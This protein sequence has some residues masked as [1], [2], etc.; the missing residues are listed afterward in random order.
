MMVLRFLPEEERSP[1]SSASITRRSTQRSTTHQEAYCTQSF[2]R[3]RSNAREA[4]VI[5]LFFL[6]LCITLG[7]CDDRCTQA[8][9]GTANYPESGNLNPKSYPLSES[10]P[11]KFYLGLG[12]REMSS[13]AHGESLYR[14]ALRRSLDITGSLRFS[15]HLRRSFLFL[16]SVS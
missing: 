13:L 3:A 11:R 6:S 5:A 4:D 14:L 9:S 2:H 8:R 1:W 16:L 7:P 10:H 12:L 15:L